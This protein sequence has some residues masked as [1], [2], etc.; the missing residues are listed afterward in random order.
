M[1]Q[2][3]GR[4]NRL[5]GWPRIYSEGRIITYINDTVSQMALTQGRSVKLHLHK[6]LKLVARPRGI[7]GRNLCPRNMRVHVGSTQNWKDDRYDSS[8][9][10]K[11]HVTSVNCLSN[12][13]HS[14]GQNIKSTAFRVFVRRLWTRFWP[15]HLVGPIFTKFGKQAQLPLTMRS[16]PTDFFGSPLNGWRH[17][18]MTKSVILH[19]LN[20][21]YTT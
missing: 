12:A 2:K 20:Y 7:N 5:D 18:H 19:P 3:D 21:F 11:K 13:M 4:T 6:S 14:N 9:V 15:H 8:V 16:R 17:G 1:G 10:I